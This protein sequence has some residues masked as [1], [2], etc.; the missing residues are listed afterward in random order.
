MRHGGTVYK[1]TMSGHFPPTDGLSGLYLRHFLDAVT[2]DADRLAASA[3][4]SADRLSGNQRVPLQAVL[5]LIETIDGQVPPGW[6][7]RPA[8]EMEAA[9]HGPLGIAAISAPT[10]GQ[11]LEALIRFQALR[12]PFL[13]FETSIN[14]REWRARII[15]V[16]D[17]D[18]PWS[19][20]MEVNLLAMTGLLRR[21]VSPKSDCIQLEIP[22]GYRAWHHHLQAE[23]SGRVRTTGRDYSLVLP[24]DRL[25]QPC[26]LADQRL[27]EDA[28]AS[29]RTLMA[30]STSGGPLESEIR[31][32]I[33]DNPSRSPTQTAMARSLGLSSRSLHRR[34]RQT[35]STYRQL[36]DE[37]KASVASHRLRHTHDP[38]ARIAEELG[39]QDA[40]NFGRACRRWFGCAPTQLRRRGQ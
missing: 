13:T 23:F 5:T 27:H 31:R 16:H 14:P 3:G 34:L 37:V 10:V 18:G 33:L 4:L 40:A 36:L 39:Y 25:D 6:H 2:A 9:H 38:V 19:V 11:G 32:R 35:G 29:C 15:T 22:K 20:L 28:L 17:T 24:R 26:P 30:Q 21:M 12:S 1:V 7:V 8:L